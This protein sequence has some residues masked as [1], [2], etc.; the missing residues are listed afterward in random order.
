MYFARQMDGILLEWKSSPA[1]KPLVLRGARQTGKTASVRRLGESYDLFVEIN[2][3]RYEDLS[4][5]RS[6]RSVEDLLASAAVKHNVARFPDA[7]LLFLDEI[8]S[9]PEAVGWLRHLH[10][11][12]PGIHVVAAGSSLDV[13]LGD[14]GF[15]FPVGR[16][17]FRTL[18]PFTFLEF[19]RA[20]GRDVLAERLRACAPEMTVPPPLHEEASELL[21]RYLVVGGMPEAVA[22]WVEQGGEV[23]VGRVHADLVQSFSEDIQ[24]Y[25]GSAGPGPLEAAFASLGHHY[26][27][28]FKYSKFA[29]G[30]GSRSM[31]EALAKLEGALLVTI[32][33]PTS[34]LAPPF[35]VKPRSAPKLVP[36]DVGLALHALGIGAATLRRSPLDSVLDGRVAEM[37]AGQAL[38]ASGPGSDDPLY[39][40]VTDSAK[41]IAEVDFVV[42]A[43]GGAVPVEVKAGPAGSLKSLHLFLLRSGRGLGVRLHSGAL[44]EEN[45]SV[46]TPE[47]RMDYRL[48]GVPLYLAELLPEIIAAAGS[49]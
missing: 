24:K 30:F 47:R 17:T 3:E 26:G 22:S 28:R 40:W 48:L 10:E 4:M 8:Q 32:A 36:L 27:A 42:P 21:T 20:A 12:H 18:R 38:L 7:T 15:S 44:C 45:I 11:D 1:R 41:G 31:K 2:L 23:P 33:R 9:H 35:W 39:F 6:C 49:G 14:R 43:P 46:T 34:S 5:V 25:G 13:R 19:L 16:V 37:S 29:P